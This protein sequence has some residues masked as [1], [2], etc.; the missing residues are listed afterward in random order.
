M[1]CRERANLL[2]HKDKELFEIGKKKINMA[3]EKLAEFIERETEMTLK[4]RR[5]ST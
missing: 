5:C 1:Y 3:T 2:I 4:L